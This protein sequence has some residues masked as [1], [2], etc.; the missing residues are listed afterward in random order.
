[1]H[2]A[3]TAYISAKANGATN[4]DLARLLNIKE[5]EA[6]ANVEEKARTRQA[7]V[8]LAYFVALVWAVLRIAQALKTR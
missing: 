4:D 1:M 5:M 3:D 8:N 6:A 7:M 2:I